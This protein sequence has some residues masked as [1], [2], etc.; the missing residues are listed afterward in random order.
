MSGATEGAGRI[1]RNPVWVAIGRCLA[2]IYDGHLKDPLPECFLALL[3]ELDA[4]EQK[5]ASGSL[6]NGGPSAT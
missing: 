2:K 5:G 6:K 1:G 4:P 3:A